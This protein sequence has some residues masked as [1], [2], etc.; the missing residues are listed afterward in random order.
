M[1]PSEAIRSMDEQAYAAELTRFKLRDPDCLGLAWFKP[2][3]SIL[4]YLDE[5]HERRQA[6]EKSMLER[7]ARLETDAAPEPG[8]AVVTCKCG[9]PG[10]YAQ[11]P[12]D[13]EKTQRDMA[14]A[15]LAL[16]ECPL[17]AGSEKT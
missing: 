5:E 7:L 14:D 4:A 10:R 15:V 6:F 11:M 12:L 3:P 17:K 9:W 8:V 1:K 13:T 16:H 2:N